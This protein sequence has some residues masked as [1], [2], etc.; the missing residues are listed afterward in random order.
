MF[1]STKLATTLKFFMGL[2]CCLH[3]QLLSAKGIHTETLDQTSF[4]KLTENGKACS[5]IVLPGK[6]SPILRFAAKELSTYLK[7][8]TDAELPIVESPEPGKVNMML[9]EKFAADAGW[10]LN[11]IPCDGFIIRAK[12]N[13][14]YIAGRDD[15][16]GD[17][18]KEAGGWCKWERGTLYGV[19]DFLERFAGVR[20]YFPGKTGT[21]TPVKASLSVP[22]MDITEAPD[23]TMRKMTSGVRPI[24]GRKTVSR[25]YEGTPEERSDVVRKDGMNQYRLRCSSHN[26]PAC[27]GLAQL[28]YVERFAK[29]HPEYF[30]LTDKG[31]RYTSPRRGWDAGNHAGEFGQLC[32]SDP[33]L[34][35][36]VYQDAKAY[37]TGKSAAEAGID[38]GKKHGG[39]RWP[40]ALIPGYFDIMPNDSFYECRCLL[41]QSAYK[42]GKQAVSDHVW[43]FAKYLG[44]R[45]KQDKVSGYLTMMSYNPYKELPSFDLPDNIQVVNTAVGPWSINTKRM[46]QD[47]GH[48]RAWNEK[49]KSKTAWLWTYPGDPYRQ[50][51]D[52]PMM[53]P[54]SVGE[55]FKR[56][57]PLIG[58]AYMEAET[59]HYIFQYLN[60]YMFSRIAWNSSRNPDDI[61]KEHFHLMYG[62]GADSMRQA[63]ELLE[64]CWLKIYAHFCEDSADKAD[65]PNEIERWTKIYNDSVIDKLVLL[66]DSAEKQTACEKE[67]LNRVR[68]MRRELFSPM[69]EAR[70]KW[71]AE[72]RSVSDW[73]ENVETLPAGG[74]IVFDG[75]TDEIAWKSAWPL[76]LRLLGNNDFN[77]KSSGGTLKILRDDQYI[78]FA[79]LFHNVPSAELR[80]AARS[81][82]D[83]RFWFET[84]AEVLISPGG[85]QWYQYA[86]NPAGELR[87]LAYTIENSKL[88]QKGGFQSRSLVKCV[89]D[90]KGWTAEL[91]IPLSE[92]G[93]IRPEWEANFC[94]SEAVKSRDVQR[95]SWSPYLKSG[96]Q[97]FEN[98]GVLRLADRNLIRNGEF[99]Q[100]VKNGKI[101]NWTSSK[102]GE[103]Q[104]GDLVIRTNSPTLKCSVKDEGRV[105]AGQQIIGMKPQ[106]HYRF[107]CHMRLD[108]LKRTKLNESGGAYVTLFAEKQIQIP[109]L[110][111]EGTSE[112]VKLVKT[113]TTDSDLNPEKCFLTLG[114]NNASGNVY[115]DSVRLEEIESP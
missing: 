59:D 105:Y 72:R 2:C 3:L 21:I 74:K 54:K 73:T 25:W 63:Y 80:F 20:F 30:A 46:E 66:L 112:W 36:Q 27:H 77:D 17:P 84:E 75:G 92:L 23:F 42:K 79:F 51:P 41:C 8:V 44:E 103:F 53:T 49:N 56:I 110:P 89:L 33:G 57:A 1:F 104:V 47:I 67:A 32:L 43:G 64:M 87:T 111:M 26:I 37:L 91:M 96:F 70:K 28:G 61:L 45:L 78:Y 4:L 48:I 90:E 97:E 107:S 18:V 88:H 81:G 69:F 71:V 76:K 52:L 35:K 86:F 114:T 15:E 5:A 22:S 55:Y 31:E 50:F 102:Q 14:I 98:F 58:G 65:F 38:L 24:T 115:F 100:P 29:S 85:G 7:W 62:S 68:F 12:G 39:V 101:P 10:K 19:Y 108:G 11:E 83:K 109:T 93:G 106:T 9:G 82:D 34:R 94:Y 95:Y 16:K 40:G 13:H 6:A 99:R 60:F 113:F